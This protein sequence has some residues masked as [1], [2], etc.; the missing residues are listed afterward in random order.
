[1]SSRK[2]RRAAEKR[3]A[4]VE[5]VL[6]RARAVLAAEDIEVLGGAVDLFK[7]EV[8]RRLDPRMVPPAMRPVLGEGIR[9][10]AEAIAS[11]G[12]TGAVAVVVYKPTGEAI[13]LLEVLGWDG[14]APV[15]PLRAE[16]GEIIAGDSDAVTARWFR[17]RRAGRI[18]LFAHGATSLV[19]FD[20]DA[21]F[22]IEPGATDR[23][24]LS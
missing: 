18:F 4:S 2:E 8:R 21:G 5:R 17:S 12:A 10:H 11:I 19:N 23:E 15:F 14:V 7:G 1:M 20:R 16:A 3:I 22:T 24:L 6:E 9:P 13:E